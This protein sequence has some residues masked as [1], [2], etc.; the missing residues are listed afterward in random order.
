[1]SIEMTAPNRSAALRA[2]FERLPESVRPALL[3]AVLGG[4]ID[5]V[6][7]EKILKS[8][9]WST[10]RDA[11]EDLLQALLPVDELVPDV[12]ENWRPV[13]RD[14]ISFIGARLSPQRLIPKLIEQLTL[15][16]E[17]RPDERLLRF[18]RR[19][20]S[21]QKVGQIIARNPNL[22]PG[23]RDMLTALEDDIQDVDEAEVFAAVERDLG[24]VLKANGI[25][26]E[27]RVFAEGTVSALLRF[28]F[29]RRQPHALPGGVL[30]VLKP[31]ILQYFQE[32]LDLLRHLAEHFDATRDNYRLDSINLRA[33]L[34]EVRSLFERETDFVNERRSLAAAAGRYTGVPGIRIPS[35][36]PQF[37]TDSITAMTEE[38]SVKI[39][40]AFPGDTEFRASIARRLIE[41]LVAR[42]IFSAEEISP[43]HAD[44]HAGNLRVDEFTGDLV[45]LDWALTDSLSRADRRNLMLL[46]IALPLRDEGQIIEALYQLCPSPATEDR[47]LI[48]R[49]VEG[50]M[51][52]LP[53]GSVPGSNGVS[54]L[55]DRL[56]RSGARFSGAFLVFRKM[57]STLGNVVQQF[58]PEVSIDGV[59]F[60]YA[61][62]LTL[63]N[64]LSKQSAGPEFRLPLQAPDVLRIGFSAQ[65]F[66]PR[67]WAQSVRSV[68]RT[69]AANC[70]DRRPAAPAESRMES[71]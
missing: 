35:P 33:I 32:E 17:V 9:D 40:A 57:L 24:K 25:H 14:G 44:P 37:S 18:I 49:Q 20:P 31:F 68:V 48:K 46:Y 47:E 19:V 2:F 21:L 11:L 27:R 13:V 39:T 42:P 55:M 61:A 8:V 22:D 1:M 58:A 16:P 51:D 52:V 54:D 71:Q 12:Y 50:F 29:S 34:D 69:L 23:F 63:Q 62:S 36:F 43:F 4:E 67:V 70:Q 53:F 56:L 7:V 6:R 10:R 30:K 3:A 59:V 38:P 64:A 45:L 66:L 41:C 15:P 65:S 5:P 60:D 26:W 28:R